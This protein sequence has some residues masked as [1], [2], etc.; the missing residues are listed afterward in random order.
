MK[1][2]TYINLPK[3]I[4]QIVPIMKLVYI[5]SLSRDENPQMYH[6][7]NEWSNDPNQ[8]KITDIVI[9]NDHSWTFIE[10]E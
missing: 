5:S 8:E 1:E 7:L 4:K 2:R 3:D 10:E 6:I 9:F